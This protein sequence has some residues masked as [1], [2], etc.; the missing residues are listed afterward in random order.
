MFTLLDILTIGEPDAPALLAPDLQPLTFGQLRAHVVELAKRLA[1]YGV[2]RSERVAIALGNGPAIALS[3]LAAATCATAAPLNPK[4]RQDEFAFYFE[5]TR[6]TT[7]IVP[8]D[9]MAAAR[10]A[11]PPGMTIVVAALRADGTLDLS[12]ERGARLPQPFISP[13]PDDVALILH[14]SGTT[15][16]PK[17]VPL[18]QRNLAASTRNIID[19]YRLSPDDRAL[20]VMPLFHIHGIVATLLAPL[21][22][23][24]SV[25]LPPGFDAM[26]FWGWLTAFRPTWFSAVPTMHQ[27]LLARAERQMTAIRAAPLRFIRSS[28]A[29]LPPVVL[30][31]LE[32]TFQ[33]PV[34]ESYGMTEASHQ[35]TTNPLPPLPHRAGSV[36]YGFGVEVTILDEQGT[37]KPR[38]EHGEVAVRGPNVFDGYENNPEATAAAFTNGWF[39]T[40]DQ[41]RIDDDGYLWLTGRLKELINRGGEK[42]SPLEIDDVLLRHPAVAEA[43][44]FAAPHRTLGEEVHAAVVLRAAATE[45]ELRDHCAAFLADFKVPRVI[46]ILPEIPRGATGKVQ[47]IWMAKLLKLTDDSSGGAQ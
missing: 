1:A 15:S 2:G 36:G 16:R 25:V 38:G 41:G 47:R 7:L 37:E 11:A 39:R 8:P 32:A 3:F 24:G 23:G 13:Q 40:G 33:A 5:D 35:M 34:I 26:R 22:S 27:M 10:A 14:T 17:R 18:R 29:P 46:H 9:G 19:A 28:S 31:Q 4:Y 6:A 44:T 20:C 30:E 43:V 45:R 21:A 42:I 12:L